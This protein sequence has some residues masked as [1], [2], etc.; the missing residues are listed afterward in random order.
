MRVYHA[1]LA[2]NLELILHAHNW[3]I[4]K[5]RCKN[6]QDSFNLHSGYYLKFWEIEWKFPKITGIQSKNY[7]NSIM[8]VNGVLDF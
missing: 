4:S 6:I 8:D 3:F 7:W 2:V 5:K 1:I